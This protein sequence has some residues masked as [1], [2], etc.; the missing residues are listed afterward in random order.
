M[1]TF[2]C[3]TRFQYS[4]TLNVTY[5]APGPQL[6]LSC[7]FQ[8]ILHDVKKEVKS[9]TN[10]GKHFPADY[11]LWFADSQTHQCD[12]GAFIHHQTV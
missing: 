11:G 10:F 9:L 5:C 12:V 2:S 6:E 1:N 4:H 8:R 3:T 7:N